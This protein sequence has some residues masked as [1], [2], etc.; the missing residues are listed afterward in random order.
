MSILPPGRK[1]QP[2]DKAQRRTGA[3]YV[4]WMRAGLLRQP[5]HRRIIACAGRQDQRIQE[6]NLRCSVA[7]DTR[8]SIST[9]RIPAR[10]SF[11]PT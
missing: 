5:R 9:L 11:S 4:L 1:A 7:A 6:N 2:A 3:A 10:L 8:P